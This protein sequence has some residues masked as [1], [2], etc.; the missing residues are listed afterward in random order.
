LIERGKPI[1]IVEVQGSR[2]VVKAVA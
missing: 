2:V 1:T